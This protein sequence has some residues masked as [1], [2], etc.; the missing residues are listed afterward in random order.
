MSFLYYILHSPQEYGRNMPDIITLCDIASICGLSLDSFINSPITLSDDV[1]VQE[2]RIIKKLRRCRPKTLQAI[3]TILDDIKQTYFYFFF[4]A[5]VFC[6]TANIKIL[7]VCAG[8][9]FLFSCAMIPSGR[10][11]LVHFGELFLQKV[12]L[13]KPN[14]GAG[15]KGAGELQ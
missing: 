2:K 12:H 10:C 5:G 3:E 6:Q 9:S 1:T 13:R 4:F 7:I 14:A 8:T 15:L 11:T